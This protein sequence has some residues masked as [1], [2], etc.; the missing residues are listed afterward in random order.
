M[1][2]VLKIFIVCTLSILMFTSCNS[3]TSQDKEEFSELEFKNWGAPN[4]IVFTD[5]NHLEDYS[6]I[7]V[8]G[9]FTE[10]ASQKE[11]RQ[12]DSQIGSDVLAAV[13]STNNIKVS[14]VIKGDLQVGDTVT[15]TQRYG[16][17]DGKFINNSDLTPMLKGDTWL[18]FLYESDNLNVGTY[19][20]TGDSDGRYPIKNVSYRKIAF[21]DNEDIGVYNKEDFREDIYKEILEK[22]DF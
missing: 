12:Y 21:T 2:K 22:Y 17:I 6:D 10:D 9:S 1:K 13:I 16:I 11:I 18:F 3:V 7:I 20:C 19:R 5:L 4:R 14:K 15:I 8:I